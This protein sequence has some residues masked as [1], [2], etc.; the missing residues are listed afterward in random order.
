MRFATEHYLG[1]PL[2]VAIALLWANVGAES[3]FTFAHASLFL[4][5]DIGMAFFLALMAKEV[6]EATAPGGVLHSWRLRA[7]PVVAAVGGM[8]GAALVY[9]LWLR[10][11]DE[12]SVLAPGWPIPTAVDLAFTYFIVKAIFRR[13]PAVPFVLVL[14]IATDA[15][16][17]L[18]VA[19]R[20]PVA[21]VHPSGVVLMAAAIL[22]AIGLRRSRVTGFW[23]YVV[24]AGGLSWAA[25]YWGGLHPA[26]ALVPIVP[27]LPHAVHD[28]GFLAESPPQAHD[29]LNQFERAWRYPVQVVIFLF[30]LVNGGVVT[31]AF[32][33]G[34][35]SVLAGA[36]V[37]KPVGIL[38]AVAGGVAAGLHLSP[39]LGWRDLVVVALAASTG[40]TFALLFA[41]EVFPTGP[42]LNEVKF[43]ALLTVSGVLV[44][45]IVARVLR[46]GMF[47]RIRAL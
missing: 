4:V 35:W 27:F 47:A 33:T 43:G 2:G 39:K 34:T 17:S 19:L 37:G 38:A 5:N 22:V 8:I 23:P 41:A 13:H 18:I 20:Y 14:A 6:V 12:T 16:G 10:A 45:V 46:V 11:G 7:L 25:F 3:Y 30:G 31:Q 21:D 15:L 36:L 1:L 29:P 9:L 32:G 24:F 40:F 44:A 42:V 26:F 28:P